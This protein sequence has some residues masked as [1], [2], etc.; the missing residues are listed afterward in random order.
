MASKYLQERV[1]KELSFKLKNEQLL[2]VK[3]LMQGND[4]LA[5]L[6][7]GFGKS[8]IYQ[9]FTSLKNTDTNQRALV[10]VITPLDSLLE[11]Q[12]IELKNLNYIAKNLADLLTEELSKCEFNILLSS[13]EEATRDDFQCELK[14]NSSNIHERFSCLVV[15]ECHTVE[16]WTGNRSVIYSFISHGV[17]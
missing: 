11:D 12:L 3:E 10:L 4:V 13:A 15:D 1:K 7:T 2:A 17:H 6:P 16:T 14:D 9:A 5:I 8:R